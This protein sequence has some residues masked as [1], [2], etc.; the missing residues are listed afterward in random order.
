MTDEYL[1]QYE[2]KLLDTIKSVFRCG[3]SNV[4]GREYV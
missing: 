2:E 1:H 4:E 3:Q